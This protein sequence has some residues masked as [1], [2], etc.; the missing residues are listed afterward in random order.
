[1]IIWKFLIII[2][3]ETIELLNAFIVKTKS[4]DKFNPIISR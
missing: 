1:M 2:I 4:F 3:F